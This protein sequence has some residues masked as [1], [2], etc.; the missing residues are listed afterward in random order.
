MANIPKLFKK[1]SE[2]ASQSRADREI[3]KRRYQD[4]QKLLATNNEV[5]EVMADMEEKSS[6][7]CLFD[8]QYIQ[9]TVRR[10]QNNVLTIIQSL[11]ALSGNK[12]LIFEKI[13]ATIRQGTDAILEHKVEIPVSDLVIPLEKLTR[14]DLLIAG[15]KAANLGEITGTLNFPVPHGFVIGSYAF[16]GFLEHNRLAGTIRKKLASFGIDQIEELRRFSKEIYPLIIES[17]IPPDLEKAILDAYAELSGKVGRQ[18]MVSVRSSAIREDSEFSFAGQYA[19][20]L[21]IPGDEILRKYREVV[22]SL[23][24][25]K[26]MFYA[27]TKGFSQDEMV[28]AVAVLEMIPASA[29]GVLYTRDPTDPEKDH[30]VINSVFGL[31]KAVVDGTFSTDAFSVSRHP[32]GAIVSRHVTRK[33]RMLICRGDR[34]IEEA[35]V[36]A[37][38]RESPSLTDEQI[39]TLAYYGIELEK[40]FGSAC[41]IEFAAGTDGQIYLLQSRPLRI[42]FADAATG[43][44]PPARIEGYTIMLDKGIIASKGVGYGKAFILKNDEALREFPDGA[45]LVARHTN[46][47][48]VTVMNKAAA[49]IT[50]VGSATDHM[51]SLAREY[52]VPAIVDAGVAT[53]I[54]REGQEITVDALNCTIYEGK[55]DEIIEYG[56][57]K[58]EQCRDTHLARMLGEVLKWIVPLGLTDPKSED[59]RPENCRTYH[60]IT[61]FAHE[62]AMQEMFSIGEGH[63]TDSVQ[64]VILVSGIPVNVQMLDLDG[65]IRENVRQATPEDIY[66]LPFSALLKGM[67]AMKWPEPPPAG[68]KGFFSMLVHTVFVRGNRPQETEKSSYAVVSRNYMNFSIRLGYHFSLVEAYVSE[69]SNDNYIKFFFKGGGASQDRRLRRAQLVSEI[70]SRMD[71][72]ITATEDVI[73]A[74]ITKYNQQAFEEKLM[75]LGR[76]TAYTKQL[77]MVLYNDAVRD[78]YI[79]QFVKEYIQKPV[80][81]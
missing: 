6:G 57:K 55:V 54:I 59:F 17:E 39:S 80:P 65:G 79:E 40:H 46:P 36:S 13:H 5:L 4:F 25:P 35:P 48:Y 7:E 77:D 33:D 34:G 41:D 44:S 49:I 51:A 70:L 37:M 14:R 23:F 53:G 15:G 8:M 11:N 28:M 47:K 62:M 78:M 30:I 38:R 67:M 9:S 42:M 21:N 26:A 75:V 16:L 60:D 76:L 52:R 43:T 10:V 19:T 20:F 2:P 24:T 27:K 66:S 22:A 71:F 61:R 45:V 63:A 1:T 64:S 31:G 74:V 81:A 56:K 32:F 12:Y 50:D 69:N 58:R 18:T 29:G 68:K 73:D 72:R 3:L